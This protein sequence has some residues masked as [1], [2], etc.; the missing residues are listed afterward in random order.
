MQILQRFSVTLLTSFMED[1]F[2][3]YLFDNQQQI[4]KKQSSFWAFIETILRQ[5]QALLIPNWGYYQIEK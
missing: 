5:K 3:C 1:C 4:Y 2:F